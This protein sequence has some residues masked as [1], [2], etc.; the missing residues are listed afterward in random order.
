MK[1]I[2]NILLIALALLIQSTFFGKLDLF[3][4]RP[5][6]ALIVMIFLAG[7]SRASELILYGFLIGFLQ[8]VYS[9]EYLGYNAFSMSLT[10]FFLDLI[11]E[12]LTVENYTV[13][14]FTTLVACLLH[15]AVYLALVTS[16]ET[17]TLVSLFFRESFPGAIYT[18]VLAVFIV[19]VWKWAQAGG[20]FDVV[21]EIMGNGR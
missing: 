7:E 4:V 13:R 14:L 18:A 2:R 5:D 19:T 6:L 20:L 8:D 16:F 3:G 12:R 21:W 1:P 9:P 15:D 11:K 10:A 17:A